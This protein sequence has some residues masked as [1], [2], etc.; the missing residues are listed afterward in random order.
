MKMLSG[1]QR[2]LIARKD[3]GLVLNFKISTK[4]SLSDEY[5][6]HVQI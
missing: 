2:F 6:F 1:L 3:I 4:Q 5:D